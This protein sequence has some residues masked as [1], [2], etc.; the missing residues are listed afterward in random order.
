[1]Y[2]L[3]NYMQTSFTINTSILTF[4][5][6]SQL[7]WQLVGGWASMAAHPHWWTRGNPD[8]VATIIL[9][10]V[11][12]T[13]RCRFHQ[14]R[15][16]NRRRWF[17]QTKGSLSSFQWFRAKESVDLGEL[18]CLSQSEIFFLGRI[19][20]NKKVVERRMCCFQSQ[21]QLRILLTYLPNK[22]LEGAKITKSTF[23]KYLPKTTRGQ[24]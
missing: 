3:E 17:S 12:K 1:M 9:D 15:I 22:Q 20:S 2:L 6:K 21:Q 8:C 16:T 14:S 11:I 10:Q 13:C 4:H 5:S 23:Q 7:N 24:R 19:S 18:P